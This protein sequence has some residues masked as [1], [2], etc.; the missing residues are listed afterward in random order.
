V[1]NESKSGGGN[2]MKICVFGASAPVDKIYIDKVQELGKALGTAGHT[3]VFGGFN[4]G[5]M[6]AI[7]DGFQAAGAKIIGVAPEFLAAQRE[8][9]QGCTDIVTVKTLAERKTKMIDIADAFIAV[10][11]GI[12]TLDELYEVLALR[13]TKRV[14]GPVILFNVDG[15]YD[16]LME[17]MQDMEHKGFIFRDLKTLVSLQ[18]D[19]G[20]VVKQLK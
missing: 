10:P 6:K 15:Y 3:L 12:G 4:N 5:L 8:Y 19:A 2:A 1:Y 11:G 16:K 9:H 14:L 20:E 17:V 18:S 13:V 7:A